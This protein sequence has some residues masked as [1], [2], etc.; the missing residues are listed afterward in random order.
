MIKPKKAGAVAFLKTHVKLEKIIKKNI[1]QDCASR[2]GDMK[3]RV[4]KKDAPEEGKG[5]N[6][7]ATTTGAVLRQAVKILT[8]DITA[9]KQSK[10]ISK[11][12]QDELDRLSEEEAGTSD[13]ELMPDAATL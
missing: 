7:K 5:K 9:I 12:V 4:F 2:A 10:P 11:D 8:E 1:E 13:D 6:K 3:F